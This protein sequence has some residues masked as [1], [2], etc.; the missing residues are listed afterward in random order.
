LYNH[1][2][3]DASVPPPHETH[4]RLDPNPPENVVDEPFEPISSDD[5]VDV[6]F[7]GG[8][9][10]E[11]YAEICIRSKFHAYLEARAYTGWC[12]LAKKSS[13]VAKPMVVTRQPDGSADVHLVDYEGE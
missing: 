10:L 4:S 7:G 11:A 8:P 6:E 2:N 3:A 1:P 12:I 5:E 13:P 9:G